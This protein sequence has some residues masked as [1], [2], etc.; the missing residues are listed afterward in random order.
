MGGAPKFEESQS[1]PEFSYADFA[2]SLGFTAV[3][4]DRPEELGPAWDEVL[5]ANGPALLDVR[6][7]P[8][9]PPIPPH[10]SFAQ[11]KSTTEAM[12][13]GDPNA[14][15]M[16]LQGVKTKAEELLPH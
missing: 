3:A 12:L 11:V 5:S 6:C 14:W 7:D 2:R 16:L 13:K 8:E 1:L 15:H 9:V 4:V 10:A